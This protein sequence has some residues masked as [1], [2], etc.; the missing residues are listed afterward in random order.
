MRR[1][2][3]VEIES[4]EEKLVVWVDAND[5]SLDTLLRPNFLDEPPPH[6]LNPLWGGAIVFRSPIP[7]VRILPVEDD[8]PSFEQLQS[9][10]YWKKHW[11]THWFRNHETNQ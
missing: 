9:V 8:S 2:I 6:D 11:H 4:G 7:A 1:T 3:P 10:D 5:F